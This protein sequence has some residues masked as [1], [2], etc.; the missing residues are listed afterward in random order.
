MSDLNSCIY[1]LDMM[2]FKIRRFKLLFL[3]QNVYVEQML[4]NYE[5]VASRNNDTMT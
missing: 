3:N 1:Y 4:R 5:I 2:I